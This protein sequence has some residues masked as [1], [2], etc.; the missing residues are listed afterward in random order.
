ME[1]IVF[2]E[3]MKT[4]EGICCGTGQGGGGGVIISHYTPLY[5]TNRSCIYVLL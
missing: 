2:M 1:T 5:I 3:Q 4:N